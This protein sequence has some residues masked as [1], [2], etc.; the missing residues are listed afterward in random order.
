MMV[1]INYK[2]SQ[3]GHIFFI[4]HSIEG[5]VIVL[6]VLAQEFEIK[7]LRRLKYFLGIK[8]ARSKEGI[9]MT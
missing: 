2:E 4:K 7:D 6:I 3:G 1:G 5:I 9:F 8:V